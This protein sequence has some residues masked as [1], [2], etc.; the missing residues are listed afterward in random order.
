MTIFFAMKKFLCVLFFAAFVNAPAFSQGYYTADFDTSTS[1]PWRIDTSLAGN[2]WQTGP[3]Q[4]IIFD[5]A[6]SA[7]NVIVT[8]TLN[9]YPV[10][11]RSSFIVTV[12]NAMVFNSWNA[13][14][15]MVDFTHKYDTD[16]LHDGCFIELSLDGVTWQN[17]INFPFLQSAINSYS[18]TD[19][20]TGG[21]PA[22]SGSSNG[23]QFVQY[24]F[25]LCGFPF[26]IDS[27]LFRFTFQSDS[28]N[29]NK[30]GWMIDDIHV[31]P[32]ICEGFNEHSRDFE[33]SLFPNPG[34]GELIMDNGKWKIEVI[35]IYNML[36]EKRLTLNPTPKG[37]GLRVDISWLAPGIY[38]ARIGTENGIITKKFIK[39]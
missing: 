36:G 14:Y 15:L 3:P 24:D 22:F 33:I 12:T 6:Y 21:I 39:Q 38:F 17:I 2:I 8:D 7:P 20:I 31:F 10:N 16:S 19:T 37:E 1:L 13:I 34:S 18:A 5:S 27:L 25:M 4:K 30:E 29:S 23:W 28:I 9:P 26:P 35:E 11:N 32:N